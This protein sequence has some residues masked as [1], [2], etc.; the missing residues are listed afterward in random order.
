MPPENT[1]QDPF[2]RLA[3]NLR[4]LEVVIGDKARPV[5]AQVRAELTEAMGRRM[6]GD[7]TGALSRIRIAM[8]RLASLAGELDVEEGMLMRAIAHRFSQALGLG[9]TGTAKEAV[10]LMRR[11]AGDGKDDEPSDW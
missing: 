9:D 11:K 3:D 7:V 2:L 1:A 4:E 5:V 8:E 10:K 6:A